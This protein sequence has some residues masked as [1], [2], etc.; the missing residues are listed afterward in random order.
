MTTWSYI[1]VKPAYRLVA[2]QVPG[3]DESR[4]SFAAITAIK[5]NGGT[6]WQASYVATTISY[7]LD[8]VVV[9]SG[10]S[11]QSLW[12]MGQ[13]LMTVSSCSA[14]SGHLSHQ[15]ILITRSDSS[16]SSPFFGCLHFGLHALNEHI[17]VLAKHRVAFPAKVESHQPVCRRHFLTLCV[18]YD[19]APKG[20]PSFL[21]PSVEELYEDPKDRPPFHKSHH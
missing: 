18:W 16:Y 13:I 8:T 3:C 21:H 4:R 6:I 17:V 12:I 9:A 11:Y 20:S 2:H 10:V 19:V 5:R 7:C 14:S 1:C 15:I